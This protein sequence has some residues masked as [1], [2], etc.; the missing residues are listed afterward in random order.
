MKR[1][2][3]TKRGEKRLAANR[4]YLE[5]N[6]YPEYGRRLEDM[7]LQTIKLLPNNPELGHEAFPELDRPELRKIL[8]EHYDYWIFY[9]IKKSTIDILSIRHTLMNTDSPSKL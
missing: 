8:C 4:E 9:R 2:F 6:F 3:I 1:L 7:F 5:E